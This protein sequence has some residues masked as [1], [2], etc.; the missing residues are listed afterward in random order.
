MK[1]YKFLGWANAWEETPKELLHDHKT[2]D[3]PENAPNSG[4]HTRICHKCKFYY[5]VDTSD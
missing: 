2:E 5:F 3:R 1:D 4:M